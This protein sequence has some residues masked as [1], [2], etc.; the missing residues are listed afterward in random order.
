MAD[1]QAWIAAP[2]IAPSLPIHAG[3]GTPTGA[4]ADNR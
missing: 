2:N 1:R 3:F 4:G